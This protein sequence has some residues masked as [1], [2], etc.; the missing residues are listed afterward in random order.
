MEE[1][2]EP[3]RQQAILDGLLGPAPAFLVEDHFALSIGQVSDHKLQ[4]AVSAYAC[5]NAAQQG[6]QPPPGT[7]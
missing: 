2:T 7:L 1:P 3:L 6:P 5:E 4:E